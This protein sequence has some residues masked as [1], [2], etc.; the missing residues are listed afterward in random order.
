MEHMLEA[1]E[2]RSTQIGIEI[3]GSVLPSQNA[4]DD[5]LLSHAPKEDS[6]IYFVD[7]HTVLMLGTGAEVQTNLQVLQFEAVSSKAG[8][9]LAIE[10]LILLSFKL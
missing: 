1:L 4:T 6:S 5:G 10:A 3:S 7:N 8:N 9:Q 2:L